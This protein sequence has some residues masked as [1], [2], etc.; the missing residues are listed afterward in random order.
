MVA[1][2]GVIGGWNMGY[3]TFGTSA[4]NF[5]ENCLYTKDYANNI[6]YITSRGIVFE[7]AS[8]SVILRPWNQIVNT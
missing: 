3:K 6:I 8:G 2:S 4:A 5:S 1:N 7:S